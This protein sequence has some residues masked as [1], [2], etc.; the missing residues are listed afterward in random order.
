[1]LNHAELYQAILSH[2]KLQSH[3]HLY[4]TPAGPTVWGEANSGQTPVP[5]QGH[6]MSEQVLG[7]LSMQHV[8]TTS[9]GMVAP[10]L[11]TRNGN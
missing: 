4:C 10:A 9:L 3:A 8:A 1:M 5:S 11:S 7:Q 2:T 6:E